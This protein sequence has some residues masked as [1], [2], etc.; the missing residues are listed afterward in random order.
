MAAPHVAGALSLVWDFDPGQTY[1]Q[2]INRVLYAAE[3]IPALQGV[4]VTG[5][6]LNLVDA[7]I[8]DETGPKVAAIKPTGLT[9]DPLDRLRIDFNEPTDPTSFS[10]QQIQRLTG[11]EGDIQPISLEPVAGTINR[12][13][14]LTFPLQTVPGHYELA[15]LPGVRDRLG[16]IM[17]QDGDGVGGEDPDDVFVGQFQLADT[18]A[19]FD[20]GPADS[21]VAANYTGVTRYDRYDPAVGYGW[22]EGTVYELSRG[23]EDLTRD[24]QY[25]HDATFAV[26]LPNAEYD[27]IVTLGES[28]A[29]HD[30]MG[31][32][33]EGVLVDSVTTAADEFLSPVHRVSV[34]DGQLNVRLKDLG[35]SDTWV[36]VNGL[37]V[38]FAGPDQTGP[39]IVSVEPEGTMVGPIDR[40]VVNFSESIDE[41]SFSVDDITLLEGPSGL[42]TPTSVNRLEGGRYEVLFDQQN[43]PGVYQVAIGS[44]ITDVAGNLLDQN[45]NGVG[46]E[47]PDDSFT[48]TFTLEAGPEYVARFDFG[49]ASSAIAENYTGITRYDRYAA[50]PG[51]GWVVGYVYEIARGTDPLTRDFNYTRDATFAVDL[52]NG[53]YEVI[54]TLGDMGMPHDEMGVYLEGALYDS[55]TTVAGEARA[56]AY[57]VGI[58]DGQ[59]TLRLKD[60]GGSD[61]WVMINGLDVIFVG[62]DLTGPRV[63]SIEPEG[64]AVGPIDHIVVN[65]NETIDEATFT[66]DDITRLDGP[67]G[68][69]TPTELIRLDGN[70]FEV[71][72]APINT[73]GVFQIEIAPDIA[74]AAGNLL[75]QD[76][77]GVGGEVPDDE[78][79]TQFTLEAGPEYVARLDFGPASSAIAEGF[80]GVTRAMRYAADRG[81]GWVVGYVYE[82]ARGTDP[83]TRDFNYTRNATFGLDVANGQYDVVVTL[84]DM[85]MAHDQMGVF[86]EDTL[87][88]SVTT[89]VGEAVS[90]TYRVDVT[91]GQLSLKL[92]D[93]GGS[94]PWVMINGLEVIALDNGVQANSLLASAVDQIMEDSG[95]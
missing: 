80:T 7:L 91:D 10:L 51:Y 48:A 77:D 68:T 28:G 41:D 61:P 25:T 42:I 88:D 11:P 14:M 56:T 65:F 1:Q 54:V 76:Q 72:F 53:E 13:Y 70:Q 31:I 23:G 37:D 22:S 55:V 50:D 87:F 33:L 73:G 95:I 85:G 69:I 40:I 2:V 74:D 75:D 90:R 27:V 84:G 17:D 49:P 78:Y 94:D 34:S 58:G 63:A 81:Y 82:I 29:P 15:I 86:L 79:S 47:M 39:H 46:G 4:T 9:L 67:T 19:R 71:R 83:L 93:L 18:V 20:F 89:A 6:R 44:A 30:Q 64:T 59:L 57:R 12:Q 62:P 38:V 32:F 26:D 35:G 45:G 43:E 66:L 21:P 92:Q 24:F 3:P 36:M 8:P 52:P 16:N 5:G 60:L